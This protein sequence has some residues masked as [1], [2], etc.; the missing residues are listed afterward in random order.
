MRTDAGLKEKKDEC[1]WLVSL[2]YPISKV[3][4]YNNITTINC[5][6]F[7]F[8]VDIKLGMETKPTIGIILVDFYQVSKY[9]NIGNAYLFYAIVIPLRDSHQ[10][11]ITTILK[12]LKIAPW[13][14]EI[15]L[16]FIREFTTWISVFVIFST[17]VLAYMTANS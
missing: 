2:S 17:K 5:I 10:C 9:Q 14:N 16:L 6:Y 15:L 1:T 12:K 4:V 13:S 11:G 3:H 7:L 8:I